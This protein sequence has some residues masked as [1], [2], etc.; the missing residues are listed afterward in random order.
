MKRIIVIARAA[1]IITGL[2]GFFVGIKTVWALALLQLIDG[3][4]SLPGSLNSIAWRALVGDSVDYVEWK[5]DKRTEGITMSVR[6][7]MAKL[8]NAI[9]R[10][11]QGYTLVFLQF[12]ASRVPDNLPQNAHF[13]KWVWP[14]FRLGPVLGLAMSLIPLLLIKFP[15]S[16]RHQVEAEMIE[17]RA[18]AAAAVADEAAINQT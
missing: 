4:N 6:N 14:T 15:E 12:D 1:Q 17:R 11:I 18:L 16:L 5:I 3:F 10:F 8:S 13:Q 9:K 2:L 7:F